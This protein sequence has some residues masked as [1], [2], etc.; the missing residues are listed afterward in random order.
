MCGRIGSGKLAPGTNFQII[1]K[2]GEKTLNWGFNSSSG[3]IYNSRIEKLN[4]LWKN[5]QR[6]IIKSDCFWEKDKQIIPTEGLM[7]NFGVLYSDNLKAFS[8]ATIPTVGQLKVIHSRMPL[9]LTTSGID[10]WLNK[11]FPISVLDEKYL[12]IVKSAI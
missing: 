4:D 3:I 10:D 2:E 5:Y 11:I 7:M 12:Q 9:V 6:G 8:I 1:S